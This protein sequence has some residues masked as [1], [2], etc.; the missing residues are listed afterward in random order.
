MQI[1]PQPVFVPVPVE[2]APQPQPHH[3][4]QLQLPQPL[5]E[6][7]HVA[8]AVQTT[9]QQP[10]PLPPPSV[11]QSLLPQVP[12]QSQQQQQQQQQVQPLYAEQQSTEFV[13]AAR[14]QQQQ[15][16]RPLYLTDAQV[17]FDVPPAPTASHHQQTV[18]SP[19]PSQPQSQPQQYQQYQQYSAPPAP[20]S[21]TAAAPPAPA[22]LSE[23]R[24]YASQPQPQQ[25]QQYRPAPVQVKEDQEVA[26][27]E[28]SEKP[29]ISMEDLEKLDEVCRGTHPISPFIRILFLFFCLLI[30]HDNAYTF[31][32]E[33][34]ASLISLSACS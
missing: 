31:A 22:I 15:Q 18:G 32:L 10:V 13:S 14:Q 33:N 27:A 23:T 34:R 26:A 30:E 6:F 24:D 21:P 25:Q 2:Y 4:A 19:P 17:V 29:V 16:A 9:G 11:V 7:A 3:P 20:V 1:I 12:T 5:T 28:H 8:A